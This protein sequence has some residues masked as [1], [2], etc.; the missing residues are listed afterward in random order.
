M[1][2]NTDFINVG[3]LWIQLIFQKTSLQ[4][5]SDSDGVMMRFGTKIFIFTVYV[6]SQILRLHANCAH[7]FSNV[8]ENHPQN[9]SEKFRYTLT[10][11]N[12]QFCFHL[13]LFLHTRDRITCVR[14]ILFFL[15]TVYFNFHSTSSTHVHTKTART[16]VRTHTH[17]HA[18]QPAL[19]PNLKWYDI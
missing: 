9:T 19:I 13:L 4:I 5:L 8:K 14:Y 11:Q 7:A 10:L 16:R 15:Q 2:P 12:S 17:T 6:F 1:V 18:F 3:H